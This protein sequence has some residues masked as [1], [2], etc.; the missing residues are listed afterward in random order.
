MSGCERCW[1]DAHAMWVGDPLAEYERL[2]RERSCTPEQQAGPDAGVCAVCGQVT[3]HQ[4]TGECMACGYQSDRDDAK[5]CELRYRIVALEA[6]LRPMAEQVY[7]AHD[8][9][10]ARRLLDMDVPR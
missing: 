7:S 9:E 10:V 8:V 1:R 5:V 4:H 3:S 2:V 6:A